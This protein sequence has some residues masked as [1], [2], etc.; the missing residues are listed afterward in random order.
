MDIM[1][2]RHDGSY[3]INHKGNPYHLI[4]GDEPLW[5][6]CQE[7]LAELDHELEYDPNVQMPEDE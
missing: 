6:E 1:Y 4:E 5:T 7:A 2:K 3:T